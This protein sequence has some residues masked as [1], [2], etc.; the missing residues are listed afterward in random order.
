[1]I[2]QRWKLEPGKPADDWRSWT[3]QYRQ[4]KTAFGTWIWS[5]WKDVPYFSEQ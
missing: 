2:E 3:L 4:G 5:E 1:M